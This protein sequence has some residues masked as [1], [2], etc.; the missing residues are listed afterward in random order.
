[1]DSGRSASSLIEN[2]L[3]P[4]AFHSIYPAIADKGNY[5]DVLREYYKFTVIRDPIKRFISGYR[6]RILGLDD[7]PKFSRKNKKFLE[8]MKENNLKDRPSINFFAENLKK[9]LGLG[10][11]RHHFCPQLAYISNVVSQLDRVYLFEELTEVE[12]LFIKNSNIT[13]KLPHFQIQ[14]KDQPVDELTEKNVQALKEYYAADY[15]LI[16]YFT[17]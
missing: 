15:R 5:P 7:I 6:N 17:Q 1:M 8:V 14:G 12:E 3:N 4:D 16:S 10:I 13:K 11:V 9:Y 2:G